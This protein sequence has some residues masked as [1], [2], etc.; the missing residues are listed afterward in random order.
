MIQPHG[1]LGVVFTVF[2]S[3]INAV[4][5]YIAI[6]DEFHKSGNVGVLEFT[7]DCLG[8]SDLKKFEPSMVHKRCPIQ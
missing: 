3:L 5:D 4:I 6:C 2:A 1:C 7:T 8:V